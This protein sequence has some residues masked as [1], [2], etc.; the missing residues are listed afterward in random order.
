VKFTKGFQ[1]VIPVL[2][3]EIFSLKI[4]VFDSKHFFINYAKKWIIALVL[5]KKRNF[6]QKKSKFA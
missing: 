5:K 2:I 4:G 1:G 3:V 6:S